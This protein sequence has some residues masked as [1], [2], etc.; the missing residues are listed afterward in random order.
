[1]ECSRGKDAARSAIGAYLATIWAIP[2]EHDEVGGSIRWHQPQPDQWTISVVGSS[3]QV[4]DIELTLG[5][6]TLQVMTFFMRK[7]DKNEAEVYRHLMRRNFEVATVKFGIDEDG[8]IYLRGDMPVVCVTEHELDRLVG[9]FF[10]A[11]DQNWQRVV[12]LGFGPEGSS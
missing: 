2:G 10:A 3:Q 9:I 11:A 7:P 6:Y 4:V 8:D 12:T 1:M 5:E